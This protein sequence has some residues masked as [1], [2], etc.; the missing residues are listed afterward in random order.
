MA[1]FSKLNVALTATTAV[2]DRAMAFSALKVKNLR[3]TISRMGASLKT[4]ARG[5]RNVALAAAG[6]GFAAK[7][8][9]DWGSAVEETASKFNV[10]FAQATGE[11]SEFLDTFARKAGLSNQEAQNLVATTGAIVQGMGCGVEASGKMAVAVTELAGDLSSFNNLPTEEVLNAIQSAL[12]GEREQLKRLG[13]VIL[14]TDVQKRAMADTGKTLAKSLTQVE[15]ATAT[16]ALISERAGVAVGDLDRTMGSAANVAKRVRSDMINLRDA[17]AVAVLPALADMIG[18]LDENQE[19]FKRM[20]NAILDSSGLIISWANLVQEMFGAAA[21]T[22][23]EV[24]F[25]FVNLFKFM[26]L[27]FEMLVLAQNRFVGA[28]MERLPDLITLWDE[29]N[30][31]SARLRGEFGDIG[32]AIAEIYRGGAENVRLAMQNFERFGNT[33][34][35]TN[36]AVTDS[37]VEV[38]EKFDTLRQ[39]LNSMAQRFAMDFTNEITG[40]MT[41]LSTSFGG[42]LKSMGN[43]LVEFAFQWALAKTL[44]GVF[45]GSDFVSDFVKAMGFGD[46]IPTGLAAYGIPAGGIGP[47]SIPGGHMQKYGTSS[48]R[49]G[50]KQAGMSVSQVINFQVSAIDSRDMAKALREQAPTITAVVADAVNNS[51]GFRRQI[52]G[53]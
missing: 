21:S 4:F 8:M 17:I 35:S 30:D 10:V 26:K 51:S 22:I 33:V 45:P 47:V 14:E 12:V 13:V 27:A 16:L 7:K 19:S 3:R 53:V 20:E 2:F 18:S 34:T 49:P 44:L 23:K 31:S 24:A 11:V 9:F 28:A 15:K 46:M 50:V 29:L 41:T 38:G 42:M 6:I 39:Q 25:Q 5:L 52:V 37:V 48:S 32:R 1:T 43:R 36:D 40:A